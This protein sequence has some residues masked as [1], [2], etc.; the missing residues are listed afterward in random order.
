M[1]PYLFRIPNTPLYI[2]RF[3][4]VKIFRTPFSC[5]TYCTTLENAGK[6]L[7]MCF[8]SSVKY[9]I[10]TRVS[11]S[12]SSHTGLRVAPI[13]AIPINLSIILFFLIAPVSRTDML[14]AIFF[15]SSTLFE[16]KEP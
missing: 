12:L 1:S 7:R 6:S 16:R 5:F 4:K 10:L 9:D 8:T 3:M 15:K 14:T 13:F 2:S 11:E